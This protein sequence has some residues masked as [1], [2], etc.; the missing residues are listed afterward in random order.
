MQRNNIK[1]IKEGNFEIS[2]ADYTGRNRMVEYSYDDS[3]GLLMLGY[4]DDSI[5]VVYNNPLITNEF[6]TDCFNAGIEEKFQ[7]KGETSICFRTKDR[8]KLF[9]FFE[10]LIKLDESFS[11]VKDEIFKYLAIANPEQ[12]LADEI[13]VLLDKKKI[14]EAISRAIEFQKEGHVETIWWLADTLTPS[15]MN[16]ADPAEFV[17]LIKLLKAISEDN[18]HYQEAN[19]RLFV[20]TSTSKPSSSDE[21]KI[22]DLEKRFDYAVKSK[23]KTLID[24][25]F[26]QLCGN[27]GMIP[28]IMNIQGE[29]ATL[30]TLAKTIRD[31]DRKVKDQQAE[32]LSLKGNKD[33]Q[34]KYKVTKF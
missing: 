3:H 8:E 27:K 10:I 7:K 20:I 9:Q 16:P 21:E 31:L 18:P 32:I 33:K 13:S 5:R 29:T 19:E 6:F 30:L 2:P 34:S 1:L 24:L 23:N 12:D 15:I 28:V 11:Q 22:M 26:H 17:M 14:N 4:T 25:S